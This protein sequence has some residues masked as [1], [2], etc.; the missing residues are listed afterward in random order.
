MDTRQHIVFVWTRRDASVMAAVARCMLQ[1]MFTLVRDPIRRTRRL[2]SLTV[3]LIT[4]SQIVARLVS[5]ATQ[6][7]QEPRKAANGIASSL[8]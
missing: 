8:T 5:K 3:V 7:K 1:G 2:M 6:K 4:G